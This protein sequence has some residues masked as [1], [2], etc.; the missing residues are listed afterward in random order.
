MNQPESG[1]I[2]GEPAAPGTKKVLVIEDEPPILALLEGMLKA[3]GYAVETAHDGVEGLRKTFQTTPDIVLTDINM[4]KLSGLDY[5]QRIRAFIPASRLPVIIV[6]ALGLENQIIE[7]FKSGATDYVIKPFKTPDLLAKIQVALGQVVNPAD[8]NINQDA[9]EES[10]GKSFEM[11]R[12]GNVLDMGKYRIM[13][14]VG[15]GGMGTIYRARH[16][17]YDIDVALK[18]LNPDLAKDKAYA[19]RFLRE[20]RIASQ[21]SHPGIVKV[22]DIGLNGELL[23]YAMEFLADPSL[24][25]LIAK[26]GAFDGKGIAEIGVQVASALAYMHGKGFLHR[27]VK[28]DNLI[29]CRNGAVK[30]IDFGLAAAFGE[31]RLTQAGSFLGTPGYVA[32]ENVQSF[33]TP[34]EQGDIYSLGATLYALATGSPPFDEYS[35]PMGKLV[36]QVKMDLKPAHLVNPKI[37]KGLSDVIGKMTARRQ[38]ARF[39]KMRDLREALEGLS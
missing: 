17:G 37:S 25:A 5:L 4:P 36:A 38:S 24:S 27:D 21:L 23:F 39:Q 12:E 10:L 3:K 2:P 28:P 6:S 7:G 11:P 9:Y 19:L 33:R 16:A 30:L 26:A 22:F 15:S 34:D 13:E 35:E 1:S 14:E 18:V 32:P 20:V 8:L 31:K 29:L